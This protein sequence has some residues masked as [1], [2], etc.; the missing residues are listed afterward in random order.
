MYEIEFSG[1]DG[2]NLL[3]FL[4][5]IGALRVLTLAERGAEV[6]MRWMARGAWRPVVQHSRLRTHEEIVEALGQRVCG[7]SSIDTAWRIGDDLTISRS[8]FRK[9]L[10]DATSRATH[11]ARDTADFLSAFGSDA[12]G[13]GTKKDQITDT[14]FR[15][16]SGAGHQHFLG[17]MRELA[18]GTDYEHLHRA[19]VM[20]WDYEDGRPSLR[21]D[22]ADY[23]PHALRAED[24][25][26]D[27]IQ[28]MR[29]ANRLA[30]EGL[31]LFPTLP[32]GRRVRTVGFEDRNNETEITW[33]IWANALDLNT[34][35]SL[36]A[37]DEVQEGDRTKLARRGVVQIFRARRFTDGKY[38]NFS[39]AKALL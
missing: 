9:H 13:N 18:I 21:W 10:E 14:E 6:R 25:S 39:P 22:P 30:I 19:L 7:E 38:R 15:T 29:G 2:G 23:R 11:R 3:G 26:G 27:P 31:P 1:L 37:S 12:S 28:T 35:G 32:V 24:P 20:E 17:F 33:P 8:D 5:A 34:V 16:M 36:L 4:A